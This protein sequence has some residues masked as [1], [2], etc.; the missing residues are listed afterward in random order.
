MIHLTKE[1]WLAVKNHD[2]NFNNQFVY[3]IKGSNI[4]CRPS[5][6]L[7]HPTP[8]NIIIFNSIEDAY[9]NGYRPCA[10]CR[11]D[12]EDWRGAKAELV[13]SAEK[14]IRENYTKKFS[15]DRI[16]SAMHMDKSYLLRTFKEF[17]G[18]TMLEF[19]NRVR[20]EAAQELL[21]RPEL[22]I[23][24]ISCAVGFASASH[25]TQVFRKYIGKTPSQFRIDYIRSLDT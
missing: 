23:A 5:C 2:E 11:P 18:C 19:H 3:G 7:R 15:L 10:R 12:L 21:T 16:A 1:Q 9:A 17:N 13:R 4:V 14:L 24:Y 6:T 25:F 8:K 22:S 20:C